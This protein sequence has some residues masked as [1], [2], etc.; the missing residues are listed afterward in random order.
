[1]GG[2][3]VP[4]DQGDLVHVEGQGVAEQKEEEHRNDDPQPETARV[5]EDMEEL[6]FRYRFDALQLHRVTSRCPASCRSRASMRETK[7]SSREGTIFSGCAGM[8]TA[9]SEFSGDGRDC[10]C[11][12]FHNYMQ[13]PSEEGRMAYPRQLLDEPHRLLGALAQNLHDLLRHLPGLQLFRT[14]QGDQLAP[15]DEPEPVAVFSLVH[16]MGGDEDRYPFTGHMVDQVPEAPPADRIDPG[17][18]LVEE[19]DRGLVEYGAAERQ[20]LLPAAG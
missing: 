3:L 13:P 2:A 15:V 17:G 7:T 14:P 6:F 16:V 10:I 4:D 8:K 1:M 5:A 11:R 19:D 9:V 12:P 18:R 20:A